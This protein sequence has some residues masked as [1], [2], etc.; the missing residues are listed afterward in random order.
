MFGNAK[1]TTGLDSSIALVHYGCFRKRAGLL[2]KSD[3]YLKRLV[4]SKPEPAID[5]GLLRAAIAFELKINQP[6]LRNVLGELGLT[7]IRRKSYRTTDQLNKVKLGLQI[8]CTNNPHP[9]RPPKEISDW[10]DE[11]IE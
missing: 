7:E 6:T 8:P 9:N 2:A 11:T 3:A 4:V 5:L 10:G 1:R